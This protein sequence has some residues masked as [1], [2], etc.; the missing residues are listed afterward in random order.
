[1]EIRGP[2]Y[3]KQ[4]SLKYRVLLVKADA[5][6]ALFELSHSKPG[7][8]EYFYITNAQIPTTK[9]LVGLGQ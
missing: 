3:A 1:M 9:N 5:T 4:K 7:F 8:L 6:Y 2:E